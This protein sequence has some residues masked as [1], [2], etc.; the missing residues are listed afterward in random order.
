MLSKLV[1]GTH[2]KKKLAELQKLFQ[3]S[4][5]SVSPLSDF[6]NVIEVVED[7]NSFRENAEKKA[8]QQAVN[9]QEWVL[10]EDSGICVNAL[11]GAPGIYSARFAGENATDDDNNAKLIRELEGKS[12]LEAHY[13]C[14][15][16]LS[17]PQGNVRLNVEDKCR[18]Q[19]VLEPRGTGG[20]GYDP[21]FEIPEYGLTLAQLGNEFKSVISHRAKAF[22]KLARELVRLDLEEG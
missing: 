3:G 11:K 2:N 13:V 12:N 19:I 17:D 8:S 18:G 21:F 15:I 6:E 1:L 14:H 7:G 16:A 10:G 9:L 20:F 4:E 5:L 22:R